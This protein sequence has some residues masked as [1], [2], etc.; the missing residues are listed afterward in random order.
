MD[1]KQ[2]AEN[3][4]EADVKYDVKASDDVKKSAKAITDF[5]R[6]V[7]AAADL[8]KATAG[9]IVDMDH[10]VDMDMV[11]MVD[12]DHMMMMD[13]MKDMVPQWAKK[14]SEGRFFHEFIAQFL[15]TL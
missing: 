6:A 4:K 10:M 13:H 3:V 9:H 2:A 11:D 5:D 7:K 12:M 14:F 1:V 8:A 15:I